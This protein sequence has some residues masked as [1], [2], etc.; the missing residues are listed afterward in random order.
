MADV[1][2]IALD[3]ESS[4]LLIWAETPKLRKLKEEA[5][6]IPRHPFTTIGSL[7][8]LAS[9]AD[10]RQSN[11]VVVYLPSDKLPQPSPQLMA[12]G[13]M[14]SSLV[15]SQLK[16]KPWRLTALTGSLL[17]I[18]RL[19]LLP[20]DKLE[21]ANLKLSC[22]WLWYSELARWLQTVFRRGFFLPQLYTDIAGKLAAS[23]RFTA[24]EEERLARFSRG[25]PWSTLACTRPQVAGLASLETHLSRFAYHLLGDLIHQQVVSQ[26]DYHYSHYYLLFAGIRDTFT[27]RWAEALYFNRGQFAQ[28]SFLNPATVDRALATYKAG[29]TNISDVKMNTTTFR[30]A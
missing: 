10:L 22:S 26:Y 18:Y 5:H 28:M 15:S 19:L 11:Q 29:T 1:L 21:A 13:G 8:T 2:H 20:H 4:D 25:A 17:N 30:Y 27:R 23:W 3:A 12:Q 14:W 6:A 24:E 16:I 9:Y 7:D